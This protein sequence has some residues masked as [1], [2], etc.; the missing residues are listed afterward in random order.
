MK[1]WLIR[2]LSLYVFNVAVLLL[3]GL[4]MRGVAVGWNALWAAVVL[5]LATLALKPLLLEGVPQRCLELRQPVGARA[6][7][8]G[9][10]YLLVF[11]VALIIWVLTGVSS[12]VSIG[13]LVLGV[14]AAAGV[15]ADRLGHLRPRRRPD[16]G[17]DR[18][19]HRVG[20]VSHE[21]KDVV[22][23]FAGCCSEQLKIGSSQSSPTG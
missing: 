10:Q 14:R 19:G 1:V 13:W 5:T 4:F 22:T 12:G 21:G 17:E 11:A 6:R 15:P 2:A 20:H 8:E 9:H 7:R 18:S 16:R 3:I 23:R